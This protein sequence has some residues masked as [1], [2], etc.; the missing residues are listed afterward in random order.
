[1]KITA[2]VLHEHDKPFSVEA[3]DLDEPRPG[4][5]LVKVSA[6]G[7]CH[8]DLVVRHGLPIP[9]P[10]VFGHEGSG[11]VEAVG[12]DVTRFAVGDHVVMSFDH[13]GWCPQCLTGQPAYCTEF[14]LRNLTG[15]RMDGTTAAATE[16]GVAVSSRWFGQSSFATHAIVTE[17]NLVKVDPSLPLE[18]LCPLGCGIQTGAGAVLNTVNLRSGQRLAVFGVGAVGMAAVMAAKLVGASE[19]IAVDLDPDRRTLALELG[20]TTVIDG[21]DPDAVAKMGADT[22][23]AD[24]C[25][26]TTGAAQVVDAAISLLG[27]RGRLALVAAGSDPVTVQPERLMGRSLTYVLE[28]DAVPQVFVPQ[29]ISYWQRGLFPVD[30]LI[31][32][33]PLEAINNAEQ[34]SLSGKTIK[35]VLMP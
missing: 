17:R 24:C 6:V 13:C 21:A 19:I 35:P 20:A 12:R 23:G 15:R 32:Q 27:P 29:L 7:M 2:A 33:Y 26:D 31:R 22:Y 14:V 28:G 34:D 10:I 25:L 11:I 5:L 30:R 16:D 9:L 3:L 18:V 4:E 1:M 8:T